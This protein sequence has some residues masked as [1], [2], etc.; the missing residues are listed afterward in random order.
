MPPPLAAAWSLDQ[1]EVS[2][3]G[4]A[5]VADDELFDESVFEAS[6]AA[7]GFEAVSPVAD[8]LDPSPLDRE[9]VR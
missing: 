7:A 1:A 6:A 3:L 2:P 5:E 9:S 8:V 4:G